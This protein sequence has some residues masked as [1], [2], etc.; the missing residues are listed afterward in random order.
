MIM[1]FS[2]TTKGSYPIVYVIDWIG[3]RISRDSKP[4]KKDVGENVG[5]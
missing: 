1:I 5:E 4:S 3:N 2:V